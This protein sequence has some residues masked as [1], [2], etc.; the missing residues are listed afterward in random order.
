MKIKTK[1]FTLS[2]IFLTSVLYAQEVEKNPL[3][4][5]GS[6]D[7]YYKY[8]FS[9]F[10]SEAGA[11]NISTSFADQQNSL[12]IGMIDIVL[13]QE[14]GK[15]S[16]VGEVAFGPRNAGSAGPS[17]N[18]GVMEPHIQ[19]LYVSYMLTPELAITAGYM[20][21]FVGYEVISPTGNFNY[22]TSYLFTNGPFQNAGVKLD[23]TFSDRVSLMVGIFNDWN[24]YN[25]SNGMSDFGAQLY[26]VPVNGW[27]VYINMITGS[28]SG[29]ELDLT[30][31][32]QI[33]DDFYLGL[34]AADYSAP[35]DDGGFSGA[36]LYAQY[37]LTDNFSLGFRGE[38]FSTKDYDDEVGSTV[39]GS[40]VNAFTIS[41]NLT[42][43]PL[44]FIPEVRFDNGENEVFV[45]NDLMPTKTA[46]QL[47]FALVYAF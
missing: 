9:G 19:N 44:T 2:M 40:T 5:S 6:V 20:G 30:T 43:G 1:L 42:A 31:G 33:T 17:G 14:L 7:T 41:G 11:S 15:A 28:P 45:N 8:D 38:S 36:A 47:L 37:A 10:E 4:I 26:L 32:Y 27:D 35:D 21:T 13:S 46:S 24:L 39:E 12:S 29:T 23:Y 25:D 18:S 16:F 22:S 3:Q 34:N